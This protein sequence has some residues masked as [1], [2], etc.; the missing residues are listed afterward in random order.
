MFYLQ[1]INV[2]LLART[3]IHTIVGYDDV[4]TNVHQHDSHFTQ[5]IFYIITIIL[6][7]TLHKY[8]LLVCIFLSK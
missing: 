1:I 2:F 5:F 8:T 4:A 3:Y 7:Y 6:L